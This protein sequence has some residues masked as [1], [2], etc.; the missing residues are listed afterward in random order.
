MDIF[1]VAWE[2]N[3]NPCVEMFNAMEEAMKVVQY[4]AQFSAVVIKK[5]SLVKNEEPVEEAEKA[6]EVEEDE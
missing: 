3:G 4:A 2:M 5:V 1:A 6:E